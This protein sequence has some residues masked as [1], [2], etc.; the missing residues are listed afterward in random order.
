MLHLLS[1]YGPLGLFIL[2][3]VHDIFSPIPPEVLLLPLALQAPHNALWLGAVTTAGSVAGGLV[4]YVIG[5]RVGRPVMARWF[6]AER[7]ARSEQLFRRYDAAVLFVATFT[8]LPF[9]L[10]TIPAGALGVPMTR[11]AGA[12]L[13]ARGIRFMAE[14]GVLYGFGPAIVGWVFGNLLWV[15]LA[16][17]GAGVLLWL[18]WRWYRSHRYPT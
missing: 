4:G 11:F 1:A 6:G 9:K 7:L 8:P 16:L 3:F 10:I 17:G 12:S 2:A 18:L 5:A 15:N 13:A 14:A